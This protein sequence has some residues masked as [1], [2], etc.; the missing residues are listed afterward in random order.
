MTTT[1][2]LSNYFYCS[3]RE[4]YLND[5]YEKLKAIKYGYADANDVEA[6]KNLS[7]DEKQ[8]F[9]SKILKAVDLRNRIFDER[10]AK[11]AADGVFSTMNQ[12]TNQY[13]S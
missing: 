9:R 11:M 1:L 10:K 2:D 6:Y 12:M 5:T 13:F 8:V 3:K 7:D 4:K